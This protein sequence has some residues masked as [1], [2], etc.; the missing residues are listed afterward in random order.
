[1]RVMT[2]VKIQES[3]HRLVQD[4]AKQLSDSMVSNLLGT[5]GRTR[6]LL[7]SGTLKLISPALPPNLPETPVLPSSARSEKGHR[8]SSKLV[9][10]IQS[11]DRK[12]GRSGSIKSNASSVTT[13]SLKSFATSSSVY[14]PPTSI[15]S[16]SARLPLLKSLFRGKSTRDTASAQLHPA[17]SGDVVPPGHVQIFVF[18]DI[19]LMVLPKSAGERHYSLVPKLGLSR[20]FSVDDDNGNATHDGELASAPFFEHFIIHPKISALG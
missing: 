6:R 20:V 12:P 2:E 13:A 3:Q 8:K 7:H 11:W 18:S 9:Q 5:T 4:L 1:M 15:D 16:Q 17:P 10:A 14:G 19:V